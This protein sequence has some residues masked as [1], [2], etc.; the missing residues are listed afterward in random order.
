VNARNKKGRDDLHRKVNTKALR[1][2][3][4]IPAGPASAPQEPAEWIESHKWILGVVGGVLY[5]TGISP[6]EVAQEVLTK[7]WQHRD[8]FRGDSQYKTWLYRIAVNTATDCLRKI[9]KNV[10]SLDD[11]RVEEDEDRRVPEPE[12]PSVDIHEI[13]SVN[14]ELSKLSPTDA[15]IIKLRLQG[16]SPELIG[17]RLGINADAIRQRI[18]RGLRRLATL[19]GQENQGGLKRTNRASSRSR[20]QSRLA[21]DS[22]QE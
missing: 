14:E 11:V 5:G 1:F 9:R 19:R 17:S 2:A 21:G 13:I 18:S 20:G 10:I 16:E 15:K 8:K 3:A 6:E 22:Q 4:S 7:A 12:A